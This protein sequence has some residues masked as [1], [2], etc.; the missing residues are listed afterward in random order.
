[1]SENSKEVIDESCISWTFDTSPTSYKDSITQKSSECFFRTVRSESTHTDTFL[2]PKEVIGP[3]LD[4]KGHPLK[5]ILAGRFGIG[6]SFGRDSFTVQAMTMLYRRF[7]ADNLCNVDSD[8]AS[9]HSLQLLPTYT[10]GKFCLCL[11]IAETK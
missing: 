1:V 5:V 11:H 10:R 7:R 2:D 3:M 6:L 4:V 9:L 8:I